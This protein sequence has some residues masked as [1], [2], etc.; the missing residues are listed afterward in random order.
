MF[1]SV[2]LTFNV[3]KFNHFLGQKV[4]KK[5]GRKSHDGRHVLGQ[6]QRAWVIICEIQYDRINAWSRLTHE[7]GVPGKIMLIWVICDWCVRT[8]KTE[9]DIC[10]ALAGPWQCNTTGKSK[11]SGVLFKQR[12]YRSQ[13]C[14]SPNVQLC[15]T[16]Q[17]QHQCSVDRIDA[18]STAVRGLFEQS[19][20]AH[21]Q[22]LM[23]TSGVE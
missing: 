6:P 11:Q 12:A 20:M 3:L 18:A 9:L 1:E 4:D 19:L 16:G 5:R 10:V 7:E 17:L 13:T 14:R 23:A 2:T 22:Q 8:F 21:H 15:L